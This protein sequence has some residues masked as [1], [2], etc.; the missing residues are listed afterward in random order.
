MRLVDLTRVSKIREKSQSYLSDPKRLETE[1]LPELGLNNE[2][3]PEFPEELYKY[4]GYGLFFWQ[5]PNQFGKYLAQLSQWRISS[6]LEIGVRHG[7][8]FIIT[9]EYLRRFHPLER[10]YGVDILN[11]PSVLRY[12]RFNPKTDFLNLD[13][14]SSR[15]ADFLN[16]QPPFDLVFIDGDHSEAACRNDFLRVKDHAN[17][18]ALHDIA[19]DICPGVCKVWNEVKTQHGN[20]Y[21]F[22]EFRDQYAS[23]L[24]RTGKSYLGIGIAVKKAFL[25][26][27]R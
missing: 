15:F 16:R 1:L 9:A 26:D 22:F 27:Q 7:G 18:V 2:H 12:R 17:I 21:R 10:A 11:S 6:Y 13:S 23:V 20:E 8:T 14:R 19:S 24:T 5:Y 4:C 3:L 25:A